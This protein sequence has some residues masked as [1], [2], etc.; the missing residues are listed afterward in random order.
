MLIVTVNEWFYGMPG[1]DRRDIDIYLFD[2]EKKALEF[3]FL[4]AKKLCWV[5]VEYSESGNYDISGCK[6]GF[7]INMI[8]ISSINGKNKMLKNIMEWEPIVSHDQSDFL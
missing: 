2:D 8:D 7:K 6:N 3:C 1:D 4:T 5:E